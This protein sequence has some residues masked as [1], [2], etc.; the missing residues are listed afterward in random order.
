M[1]LHRHLTKSVNLFTLCVILFGTAGCTSMGERADNERNQFVTTFYAT[2]EDVTPIKFA[3]H[4]QEAAAMGAVEGALYN[5]G[6]DDM[7]MS[8][9]FGAVFSGMAVSLIEGD[10]NGLE[11]GLQA[12]D[13]D[14]VIVTTENDDI[15]VGDCVYVRVTENVHLTSVPVDY[16]E[17]DY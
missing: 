14:Y 1:H 3:S 13:G 11:V 2:V 9:L 8:A 5:F 4:A 6:D 12:V 7:F 10:L 17:S 16:C 15:V